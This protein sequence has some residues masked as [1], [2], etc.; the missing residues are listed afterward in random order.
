METTN[1]SSLQLSKST[2]GDRSLTNWKK[3]GGFAPLW[4][5]AKKGEQI[6]GVIVRVREGNYGYSADIQTEKGVLATP[7]HTTLER[8]VA[9]LK[10]GQVVRITYNGER[11]NKAHVKFRDYT[12]EVSEE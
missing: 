2:R 9:E 8:V 4:K 1:T 10:K 12:V 7:A 3:V 11:E 6:S 5:P